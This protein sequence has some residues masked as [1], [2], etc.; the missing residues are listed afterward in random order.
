[1]IERLSRMTPEERQKMLEGL[2]PA[3]RER[4]EARLREF[5][6]LTPEARERLRREYTE[7]QQLP[8]DK[9]DA[10]RGLFR[11]FSELPPHRRHE[12]RRELGRLRSMPS[13]DRAERIAS[14]QFRSNYSGQ[15]REMLEGLAILP[16]PRSGMGGRGPLTGTQPGGRSA[17]QQGPAN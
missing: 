13:E 2:P 7:F 1:L 9:R 6:N 5:E 12:L 15:E 4:V 10:I 14:E 16:S 17:G 11:R 3:R 8:P